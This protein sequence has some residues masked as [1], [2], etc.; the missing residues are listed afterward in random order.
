MKSDNQLQHDV[1]DELA[2]EPSIDAAAIGVAV[3]DG[4]V[5]LTGQARS[6][7]EKWTAAH[8]AKRVAGVRAVANDIEVRLPGESQRTDAEIARVALNTLEWDVWVPHHRVAVAVSDGIVKLEGEVDTQH[9][10]DAAERV[11][12]QLTG[13]KDVANL[14]GVKGRVASADVKAKIERA[15]Q[16]SAVI[17][18]RQIQVETREGKVILRGR[19]RSWA[20]RDTAERAAWAAPGVTSVVDLLTIEP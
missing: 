20:E 9:Q 5:T 11:I 10:K 15:F 17:D 18:A 1:I 6:L 16:R 3:A 4:V 19:V 2:W 12:R 8:V 7:A 14:L 13:V